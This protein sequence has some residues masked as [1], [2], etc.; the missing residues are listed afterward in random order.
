MAKPKD[1]PLIT[2]EALYAHRDR[3]LDEHGGIE[4]APPTIVKAANGLQEVAALLD[5]AAAEQAT[6]RDLEAHSRVRS[7]S[8]M[9]QA[10]RE[11][12]KIE[13]TKA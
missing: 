1:T 12:K 4:A 7:R 8:A 3:L 9:D 6:A 13:E 10:T 2:Q 5:Q 11:A